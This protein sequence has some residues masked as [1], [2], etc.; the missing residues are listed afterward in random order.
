MATKPPTRIRVGE[1]P[2]PQNFVRAG[3]RKKHIK[4]GRRY[5]GYLR[6]QAYAELVRLAITIE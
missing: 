6:S 2:M 5:V 4:N 1:L 3:E